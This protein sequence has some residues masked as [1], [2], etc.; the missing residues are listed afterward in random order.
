MG[1]EWVALVVAAV[2]GAGGL[3]ALL[4]ARPEAEKAEA[5]TFA[6]SI[7]A[8]STV[9]KNLQRENLRLSDENEQQRATIATLEM[10][11]DV[12]EGEMRI[13]KNQVNGG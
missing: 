4:R 7:G 5:E 10:R 13:I 11:L 12:L 1:G 8:Q 6:T 2:L 9:I 3:G